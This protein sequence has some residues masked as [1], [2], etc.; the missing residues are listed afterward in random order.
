MQTLAPPVPTGPS[1]DGTAA[2]APPRFELLPRDGR[3]VAA[4]AREYVRAS[5]S[6]SAERALRL[7]SLMA[8]ELP[9]PLR[10]VLT[11][12]RLGTLPHAGFLVGGLPLGEGVPASVADERP[13]GRHGTDHA[14][15]LLLLAGSLLG[16][17]LALP[18]RPSARPAGHA[19]LGP[20]PVTGDGDGC[21]PGAT[22]GPHVE[23]H[24]PAP[25][26]DWT[27]LLGLRD[28]DRGTAAF[29]PVDDLGLDSA[30]RRV[31]FQGRF[32]VLADVTGTGCTEADT[33]LRSLDGTR[34][35]ASRA[36]S[37]HPR[38]VA[39][40]EGDEAAPW[41]RADPADT[42][43]QSGD[44]EAAKALAAL[45]AAVRRRPVEVSVGA[46]ELF[47]LD[48][49]RAAHGEALRASADPH[50]SDL[51]LRRLDVTADPRLGA[52]LRAGRYGRAAG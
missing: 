34:P 38:C 18:G 39:L 40:L 43:A 2:A 17:P 23:G 8:H 52:G 50:A 35:A 48:N 29:T 7:A 16:E 14:A 15:A 11:D 44:R 24:S 10:R 33:S 4:L 46:G 1:A 37:G 45:T 19:V 20:C 31:L 3:A 22:A 42:R 41:L 32:H 47:V 49:R 5:V 12:H 28:D 21:G 6:L 9:R 25:H 51:P 36:G 13:T 26:A 27:M 30:T